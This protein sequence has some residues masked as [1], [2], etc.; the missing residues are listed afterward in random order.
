[1]NLLKLAIFLIACVA[2]PGMA[3]DISNPQQLMF[4]ADR[5]ENIIDVLHLST[6]EVAHRFETKYWPDALVAT[7]YAPLLY[8]FNREHRVAVVYDLRDQSVL[9]EITLPIDPQ[10]VVLDTT[11]SRIGIS[12]DL[13]GGFVLLSA[14]QQQVQMHLK[15][16]APT[17]DVLFDPNEI[18]IYYSNNQSGSIGLIDTNTGRNWELPLSDSEQ[19]MLLSSPSR[20]LDGRYIYVADSISG[21]VFSL[22]A[23]SQKINH[24]FD[25]GKAPARPYTT[26]EGSFLYMMDA[27]TGRFFSIE[28]FQFQ[29][30]ADATLTP[31]ID[32]ITV[33]RFDRLN[34]IL[35]SSNPSYHIYDNLTKQ[36]ITSGELKATPSG[37]QT[38]ADGKTAYI[39]FS[40]LAQVATVDL[41]SQQLGYID[42]T[43][44]G[45]GAFG[46][47]L[48]NTVCH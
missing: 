8:Y 13:D 37:T 25:V 16:I 11:G 1:M 32:M 14:Y 9:A 44:N 21:K 34:L 5:K 36:V 6:R 33:G 39:V 41:E 35:S 45:A 42:I 31:G 4:V 3:A 26:P 17:S 19:P 40:D 10:H 46:V 20:S 2:T 15:D 30:Y 28:Q 7:P 43:Q 12:N 24:T 38:A 48:S 18:D 29:P 23:Y 22:N 27:D 47:G